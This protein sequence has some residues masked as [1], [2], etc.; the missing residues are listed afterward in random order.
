M[1][2][3]PLYMAPLR[4]NR[5]RS[6]SH[7]VGCKTSNVVLNPLKLK[8]DW[9]YRLLY[10][11]LG[12]VRPRPTVGPSRNCRQVM[13]AMWRPRQ[14]PRLNHRPNL[15][16]QNVYPSNIPAEFTVTFFSDDVLSQPWSRPGMSG[17]RLRRAVWGWVMRPR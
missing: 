10:L 5:R 16:P 3:R 14:W 8:K 13:R 9:L 15:S 11:Q 1:H 6:A 12:P 4:H 7:H 2:T 17:T